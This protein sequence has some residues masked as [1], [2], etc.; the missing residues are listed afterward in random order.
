MGFGLLGCWVVW[1]GGNSPTTQQPN[2]QKKTQDSNQLNKDIK[3]K[4]D[5]KDKKDNP[6]TQ[7]PN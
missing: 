3:N 5:N 7:Q 4:K 6:T 2:N 1:L